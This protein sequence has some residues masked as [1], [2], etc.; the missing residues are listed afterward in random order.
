VP[1]VLSE[2]PTRA[3]DPAVA[4]VEEIDADG[5]PDLRVGL[6]RGAVIDV[7]CK[8]GEEDAYAD[9][10][11]RVEV[12]KKRASKGDPASRYYRPDQFDALA[13]CLWPKD[14]GPPKFVYRLANDLPRH[15][16]FPDRLAAVQRIDDT[17]ATRLSDLVA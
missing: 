10:S 17:W 3:G 1:P 16:D 7:E 6:R 12:Q 13:V 15:P 14:G 8:N 4:S 9:G 11:G 2:H 5:P